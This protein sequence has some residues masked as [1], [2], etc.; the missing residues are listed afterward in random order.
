MSVGVKEASAEYRLARQ[1][2]DCPKG[3]KRTEVGLIPE[4]WDILDI[5]SISTKVGSGK[6]PKGGSSVYVDHGRPLVRSQNIGWGRLLLEDIAFITEDVHETFLGSELQE[7]DVLLNI[8]GASIGRCSIA[9]K[10]VAGGN[11]NQH[12]CIIRVDNR[13]VDARIIC[14]LILS[15]DGQSQIDSF[16]A[17]GNREGLNFTQVKAL[18]FALSRS[19]NEQTAIANALSDVDALSNSLERL[20]T[21]KRAIKT[22][23]MQKLLTGKKRLPPFDKTHTGYKQTELGEIPEDWKDV[24][25][26]D[27]GKTYGGLTGKTKSDFGNGNAKYIPFMN[28]MSSVKVDANWLERVVIKPGEQQHSVFKGDLLFNGSS[29]TPEEVALCSIMLDEIPDLYL[30]SFCFGF[31][32]RDA[33]SADGLFLAYWFR[34]SIG[35]KAMLYLAQGATRY[36]IAKKA[37]VDMRL[38]LPNF[39]EQVA[40]SDLLSDMDKDID[41]LQQRLTKT[42][43][44]KQGMMQELLTGKTRLV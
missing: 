5:G 18:K 27:L 43:Q 33:G 21:K 26:G 10:E 4:D 20:I 6:T 23:A 29:E 9:N 3:Y 39:D 36:N 40:I 37:F 44:L 41:V 1:V 11:V 15:S 19:K 16:Q 25:F 17:G 7:N 13:K 38:F 22:A 32:L 31:R 24:R 42:Q 2:D 14:S 35:R 12:V 34:S 8:T 28:V 30:N